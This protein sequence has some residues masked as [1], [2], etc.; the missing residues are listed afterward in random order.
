MF[1]VILLGFSLLLVACSEAVVQQSNH[2]TDKDI[3]YAKLLP[4]DESY[5]QKE[6]ELEEKLKK[7]EQDEEKKVTHQRDIDEVTDIVRRNLKNIEEKMPNYWNV[8][9]SG[10]VIKVIDRI[11]I[12][13]PNQD[14]VE[15]KALLKDA[16]QRLQTEI[17]KGSLEKLSRYFLIRGHGSMHKD[18]VHV[19]DLHARFSVTNETENRFDFTFITVDDGEAGFA[20]PGETTLSYEYKNNKWR[21]ADIVHLYPNLN[22]L[23]IT[24]DDIEEYYD[25][26]SNS[27]LVFRPIEEETINGVTY[28]TYQID[29]RT[30]TRN[31]ETSMV[32]Y[33]N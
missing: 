23:N 14:T 18:H 10:D 25:R 26:Y 19:G 11:D 31:T 3:R 27:S 7:D 32:E 12:D 21:L 15:Q 6:A 9:D 4:K 28:L 24:F 8:P 17:T 1:F 33:N 29:D 2:K 5:E 20:I 16:E 22:P 13:R 30:I